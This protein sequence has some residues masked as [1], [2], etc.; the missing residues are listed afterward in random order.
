MTSPGDRTAALDRARL[1]SRPAAGQQ[2][3]CLPAH[4]HQR[5]WPAL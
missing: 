3:T 2:A 5:R 1:P 4:P